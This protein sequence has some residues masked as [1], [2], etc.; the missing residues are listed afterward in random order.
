MASGRGG[1][2]QGA[3]VRL[4][5]PSE[6]SA[7][8]GCLLPLRHLI[9]ERAGREVAS[10]RRGADPGERPRRQRD[11]PEA[12]AGKRPSFLLPPHPG[13]SEPG[14]GD[15]ESRPGGGGHAETEGG[16]VPPSRVIG[17]RDCTKLINKGPGRGCGPSWTPRPVRGPGQHPPREATPV[18]PWPRCWELT[19]GRRGSS[20]RPWKPNCR[21]GCR[22][23]PP[24]ARRGTR[25][26]K[27]VSGGP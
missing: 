2:S 23:Q 26:R 3:G 20:A 24:L 22:R 16:A 11:G 14:L 13:R 17:G 19:R 21:M 25:A 8:G 10:G 18:R 6:V 15:R 5:L 4:L 9:P 7:G 1:H 12:G 27:A